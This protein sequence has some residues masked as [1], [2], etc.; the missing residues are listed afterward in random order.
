MRCGAEASEG[1]QQLQPIVSGIGTAV[2]AARLR[3]THL[4]F[5]AG[6]LA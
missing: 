3:L 2:A 4:L 6:V 5:C 1:L